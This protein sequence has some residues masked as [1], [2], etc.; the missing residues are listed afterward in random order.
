MH[1]KR[2]KSFQKISGHP[3]GNT[4]EVIVNL[5]LVST[6]TQYKTLKPVA[7]AAYTPQVLAMVFNYA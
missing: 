5:Y 6:S 4:A 1:P 7:Q 3:V 2:Q